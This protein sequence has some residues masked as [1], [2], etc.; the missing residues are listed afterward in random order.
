MP[1]LV[2]IS[3]RHG[4]A[5]F[6]YQHYAGPHNLTSQKAISAAYRSRPFVTQGAH[7]EYLGYLTFGDTLIAQIHTIAQL[8]TST[9]DRKF[10]TP[11]GK[12]IGTITA[13]CEGVTRCPDIVNS[14]G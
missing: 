9:D 14:E 13:Y 7:Y 8:A 11:D 3:I 2:G 4:T 1:C 5:D 10:T 6:G 12:Y